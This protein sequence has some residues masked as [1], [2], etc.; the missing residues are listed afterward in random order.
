MGEYPLPTVIDPRAPAN[1]PVPPTTGIRVLEPSLPLPL[2]VMVPPGNL[3]TPVSS[4]IVG[5]VRVSVERSE[6]TT[7]PAFLPN[8]GTAL[9]RRSRPVY[10]SP[11]LRPFGAW[12]CRIPDTGTD[13]TLITTVV[14]RADAAGA[15]AAPAIRRPAHHKRR[16]MKAV[17]TGHFLW[18][19]SRSR[20]SREATLRSGYTNHGTGRVATPERPR[21]LGAV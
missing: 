15:D 2:K 20:L 11:L 5:L 8:C 16:K 12:S 21:L 17:F 13:F 19:D 1:R 7:A 10:T 6:P 9:I 18:I 14:S 3:A 4:P